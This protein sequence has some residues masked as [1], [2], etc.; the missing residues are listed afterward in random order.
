[1]HYYPVF[2]P[3]SSDAGVAGF[4]AQRDA[5]AGVLAAA[6]ASPK[7]WLVTETGA[8]HVAF[9]QTVG[10]DAYARDYYVKVMT[11]AQRERMMGV[12]WFMLSD[13]TSPSTP[14]QAMGIYQSLE[15]IPDVSAATKNEAGVAATTLG[16]ALA[17]ARYDP[18]ATTGL[19][20]PSGVEGVAFRR[21]GAQK[22][23]V[24]LWATSSTLAEDGAASVDLPL[25]GS[26]TALAWDASSHGDQGQPAPS[27]NGKVHLDLTSSPTILLED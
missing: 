13:A 20:L 5:F 2:S 26:Y 17:D 11:V 22:L 27:T 10:S 9:G 4:L 1:M 8:P 16:H 18:V 6:G 21:P 12:H 14:F 25:A 24:V 19:A 23:A 15:G 7:G 3:G